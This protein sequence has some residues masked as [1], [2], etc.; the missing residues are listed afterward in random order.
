MEINE[1]STRTIASSASSRAQAR[2]GSNEDRILWCMGNLGGFRYSDLVSD[3]HVVLQEFL[4]SNVID[5]V[6]LASTVIYVCLRQY[7]EIV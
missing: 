2:V 4:T 6:G 1:N 5:A 3:T 7:E